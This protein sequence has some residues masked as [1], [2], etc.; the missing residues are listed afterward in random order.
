MNGTRRRSGTMSALATSGNALGAH[1]RRARKTFDSLM[2]F[3]GRSR[4]S[5]TGRSRASSASAGNA[6]DQHR[7]APQALGLIAG[8][9]LL[10]RHQCLGTPRCS[11]DLAH[12]KVT[13]LAG[14]WRHQRHLRGRLKRR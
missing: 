14:V 4:A 7:L 1:A 11:G 10:K 6:R 5:T 9:A 12:R 3:L 13:A 2:V 8:A